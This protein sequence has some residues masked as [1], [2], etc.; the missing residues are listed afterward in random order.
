MT[1]A[2]T[3]K[4]FQQLGLYLHLNEKRPNQQSAD[5]DILYKARPALDLKD[6]FTQAYRPACELAVDE[7]KIGFVGTLSST[8]FCHTS[9]CEC[10][11]QI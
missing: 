11:H 3:L 9:V 6:K 7:A 4:R 2:M 5:F 1:Q 10:I 8:L